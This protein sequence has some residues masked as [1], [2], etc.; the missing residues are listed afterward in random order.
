MEGLIPMVFKAFKKNRV[1]SQY[2]CLSSGGSQSYNIA[3]FYTNSQSHAYMLPATEKVGGF[4]TERNGHHRRHKSVGDY[5]V[6]FSSSGDNMR[7]M[8]VA[9]PAP[10]KLVRFRSHRMFSCVTGA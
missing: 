5:A 3:D 4:H 2:R 7:R 9:P 1:R 6:E 8:E 10:Q